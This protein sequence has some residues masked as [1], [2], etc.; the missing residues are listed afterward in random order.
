M[1]S[2]WLNSQN[3]TSVLVEKEEHTLLQHV[4]VHAEREDLDNP[5]GVHPQAPSSC[6]LILDPPASECARGMINGYAMPPL[7]FCSGSQS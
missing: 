1:K 6:A 3:G 7:E 2:Q 5:E 4:R